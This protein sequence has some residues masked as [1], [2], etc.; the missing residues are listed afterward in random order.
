MLR[1]VLRLTMG[2]NEAISEVVFGA[3]NELRNGGFKVDPANT[4]FS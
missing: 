1:V 2:A 3:I 4:A